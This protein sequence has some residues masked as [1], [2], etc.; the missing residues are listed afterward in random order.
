MPVSREEWEKAE[1][2]RSGIEARLAGP[3][4]DSHPANY[5]NCGRYLSPLR[6]HPILSNTPITSLAMSPEDGGRLRLRRRREYS[7]ARQS[8]RTSHRSR[9]FARLDRDR[10]APH[11][12]EPA[13]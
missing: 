5:N 7:G 10:E 11:R 13:R 12:G 8:R 2:V 4:E 9:Y 3:R 6:T 1:V